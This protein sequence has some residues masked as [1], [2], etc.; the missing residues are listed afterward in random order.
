ME[1]FVSPAGDDR[2]PGTEAKPFCTI[3]R[4]LQGGS[5][6]PTSTLQPGDV[7]T[8]RSGTYVEAVEVRGLA[9]MPGQEIIIRSFPGERAVIDSGFSQFRVPNNSQWVPASTVIDPP[10]PPD[11]QSP[12]PD[13]PRPHPDEWFSVQTF[14]SPVDASRGAFLDE[15]CRRLITYSTVQD[16]R[17]DN[18]TFDT[19]YP[20]QPDPPPGPWRVL[21][22]GGVVQTFTY[23]WVYMGPGLWFNPITHRVHIR[24]TPTTNNVPGLEDYNGPTDPNELGFAICEVK[25]K[26]L[27]VA[28][29]RYL[30]F[31]DLTVRFGGDD[32]IQVGNCQS[33]SLDH[34]EVWAAEGGVRF[35]DSLTDVTFRNCRFDGGLPPWFFR[36]DRKNQY[37]YQLEENGPVSENKLGKATIDVLIHGL[38]I[39]QQDVE[40][41]HCEFVNGHDL[42]LVAA[43]THFH[44]NWIDN[45]D[46]EGLLLDAKPAAGGCIHSNVITRCLAAISM[47]GKGITAGHWSI[48]RNL[49]DLREPTAG[50]RPR[51]VGDTDVWRFGA[52][53][54][55][56]DTLTAPDGPY[57][58]FHNTFLV[59]DQRAAA[60]QHYKSALSPHLRQSFNNIFAV[61]D[62][63]HLPNNP[64]TFIPP[65]TFPGPTDGNLYHRIGAEDTGAFRVVE[66][67]S[68]GVHYSVQNFSTLKELRDSTLFTESKTQYPPGFEA[69][70]CLTDPQFLHLAADGT[71]QMQDDLRLM[72]TSPAKTAAVSLPA[73][74]QDLDNTL[75]A[76]PTAPAPAGCYR[77]D[78]DPLQ[79]GVH[80][81]YRF[82]RVP[83]P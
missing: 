47:A 52:P 9:G 75:E 50:Q 73:D 17:A 10:A 56:N 59:Y 35:V 26:T 62:P 41:D 2:N 36:G 45:L 80:G 3:A 39:G 25:Q 27:I 14:P 78:S 43:N 4:G 54:K 76:I 42:Y 68:N 13:D 12:S 30:I 72:A 33:I 46:D 81:R 20:N 29:S 83:L 15:P 40:I 16:F 18:Q 67:T 23:P 57:V 28:D 5:A 82:P 32:T 53:F 58:M 63:D 74:L 22:E 1:Y 60:Y 79:V 48:Y 6:L 61:V 34:L 70:S 19:I 38:G 55:S 64:I 7:L 8:L 37:S 71:P 77:L 31:R 44:H 49:I 69:N 11:G 24:L 21:N 65:P 51:W 66:Y